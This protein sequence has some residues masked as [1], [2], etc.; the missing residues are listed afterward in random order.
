MYLDDADYALPMLKSVVETAQG[1]RAHWVLV[2]CA[3]RITHR[4]SKFVSNRSRENWRGKWADKLFAHVG[5]ALQTTGARITPVL[6]RVPLP[7]LLQE[8]KATHGEDVQVVDLRRPKQ[9][10]HEAAS[11]LGT[12]GEKLRHTGTALASLFA[13]FGVLFED[14]IAA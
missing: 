1:A 13:V 8:L 3:P 11:L 6:A 9:M 7:D 5:S 10:E 12:M 4:A 2:A 14:A